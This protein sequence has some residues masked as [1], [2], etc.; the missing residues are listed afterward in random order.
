MFDA[1]KKYSAC[2]LVTEGKDTTV[3]MRERERERERKDEGE[4]TSLRSR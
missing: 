1:D 2:H 4:I 3:G